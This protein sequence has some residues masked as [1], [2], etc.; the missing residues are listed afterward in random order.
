MNYFLMA[1]KL[2]PT[3]VSLMGLAE[4][5]IVKEGTK[6]GTQKKAWVIEGAKAMVGGIADVST[7]GQAETWRKLESIVDPFIDIAARFMFWKE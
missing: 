2:L 5:V 7:G 1:L 4:K 3:V 6:T